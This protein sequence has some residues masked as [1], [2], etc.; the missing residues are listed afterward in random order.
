MR[1]SGNL[2]PEY[3]ELATVGMMFHRRQDSKPRHA[4]ICGSA[5]WLMIT[6][7]VRSSSSSAQVLNNPL[8]LLNWGWVSSPADHPRSRTSATGRDGDPCRS[9]ICAHGHGSALG[10]IGWE[11]PPG[12]ATYGDRGINAAM[13]RA[14][15]SW[16][17]R[18]CNYSVVR[19]RIQ[20]PFAH[21]TGSSS[22][23]PHIIPSS[24]I[25]YIFILIHL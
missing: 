18:A 1:T 16:E 5:T 13:R 2:V 17:Y 19:W 20:H 21:I 11:K 9:V 23:C 8:G 15:L 3:R 6:E 25:H 24:I 22:A 14:G 12:D 7:D 10:Q 4:S